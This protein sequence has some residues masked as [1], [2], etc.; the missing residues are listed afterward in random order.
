MDRKD[1]IE[2]LTII[3]RAAF[4]DS[5]L[6]LNDEMSKGQVEMWDSLT[7]LTMIE[8][9]EKRFGFRFKLLE[10]GNM[11]TVGKICDIIMNKLNTNG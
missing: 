9:V 10:L 6:V 3:F 5:S 11:D 1:I 4:E 2:E 7:F 8:M